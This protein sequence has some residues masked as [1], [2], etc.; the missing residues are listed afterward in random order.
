MVVESRMELKRC[1]KKWNSGSKEDEVVSLGLLNSVKSK[2]RE[3]IV[4]IG[5]VA[6]LLNSRLRPK[7]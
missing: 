7:D 2:F 6:F 4:R 5:G 1:G 3:N